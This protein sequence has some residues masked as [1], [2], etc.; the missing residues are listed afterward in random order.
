MKFF[1]LIQDDSLQ[2]ALHDDV[3]LL[4][5]VSR[6]VIHGSERSDLIYEEAIAYE[7]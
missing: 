3:I 6:N 2:R 5:C 1:L 7:I 4:E